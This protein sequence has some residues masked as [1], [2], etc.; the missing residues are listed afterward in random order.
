[1]ALRVAHALAARRPRPA[2]AHASA[3]AAHRAAQWARDA[4]TISLALRR[5]ARAARTGGA[6]RRA[7]ELYGS[8]YESAAG[9]RDLAGA[10]ETA[11]GAGNVAEEEGRWS[12]A[13]G[14]YV[15]ALRHLEEAGE[16]SPGRW[17]A[18][19][20]IHVVVRSRG[21][22]EGSVPWLL[23][24]QQA[25]EELGDASAGPFLENAWGQLHMA[26]GDFQ[27]AA[28]V[29][30]EALRRDLSAR[31]AVTIRLNLGET[32]LARGHVLDAAEAVR[33]AEREALRS[34]LATRLPEVYR[35]MG[36]IACARGDRNAFVL[37][38]RALQIVR[39]RALP[40]LEEALT[41]QAYARVQLELG[42]RQD[43]ERLLGRADELYGSLGIAG[44]RAAWA[45]AFGTHDD[46]QEAG[47]APRSG[48]VRER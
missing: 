20:N 48:D 38:E 12:A 45:D 2:R 18:L 23:R 15:K 14:W 24:A 34:G 13:E 27:K 39:E 33:E 43:A 41:L 28:A 47:D 19:L 25:A 31:A 16:A 36:R 7:A 8:A 4:R 17:Q 30:A 35:L 44:R 22:V 1:M 10:A 3:S 11:I 6:R 9:A 26:R 40:T 21:D 42:D 37:F 46:G 32:M 29:L 5:G